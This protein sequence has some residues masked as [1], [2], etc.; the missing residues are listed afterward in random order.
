MLDGISENEERK[1]MKK[2]VYAIALLMTLTM[3]LIPVSAQPV[4]EP[5]FVAMKGVV[6]YYGSKPA[7]GC[8]RAFAEVKKWAEVKVVWTDMGPRILSF[9]AVYYFYAAKLVK[10]DIVEL[11]YNERDFYVSGVW[12]VWN[13]TLSYDEHGKLWK[14]I[15]DLIVDDGPGDLSVYNGWTDFTVDIK[16][17]PPMEL[18]VGKVLRYWIWPFPIPQGDWN[19]D[20]T[21]DIFDLVHVAR[22]FRGKPGIE[23]YWSTEFNINQSLELIFDTDLNLDFAV[24]IFDLA[25]I[26]ANL[27]ESY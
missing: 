6:Q 27:G 19:V 2:S 21:I 15:I 11:K 10:S 26:A 4:T 17:K 16:P 5:T 23:S 3:T 12:D 24:D 8:L 18:I 22:A 20:E 25:T 9:P 7:Y 14:W 1:S 13:V